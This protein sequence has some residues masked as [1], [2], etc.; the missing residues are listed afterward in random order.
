MQEKRFV[1]YLFGGVEEGVFH[2]KEIQHTLLNINTLE[3]Y[4]RKGYCFGKREDLP[5]ELRI[6]RRVLHGIHQSNKPGVRQKCLQGIQCLDGRPKKGF[7]LFLCLSK[8]D[9]KK[10]MLQGF[11]FFFF[12]LIA[13]GSGTVSD[14]STMISSCTPLICLS[15][16]RRSSRTS[17][18]TAPLWSSSRPEAAA[19]LERKTSSFAFVLTFSL[20]R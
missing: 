20:A 19:R 12:Q 13:S 4:L 6:K 5:Y 2:P 3:F 7:R 14:L 18:Y 1:L 11:K 15:I 9:S 17:S 16:N 10:A 8:C